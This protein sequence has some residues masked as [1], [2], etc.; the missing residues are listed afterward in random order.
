MGKYTIGPR[1]HD[2]GCD[3]AEN[4]FARIV[5]DGYQS[6]QLAIPK[7]IAGVNSYE[8]I[9]SEV[10][11][12]IREALDKYHL[13]VGVLGNYVE[14]AIDDEKERLKN[15]EIF[16]SQLA[17][18]K[19]LEA[20]CIGT[21]TTA[22]KLQPKGT[23]RERGLY[24]LCKSLE[25]ILPAAEN[26]GVNVAIEAVS[27]HSMNTP[28]ATKQVLDTMG[29]KFLKVIFDAGNLLTLPD[30]NN[31]RQLWERSAGLYGDR[32]VAIHY[33][34]Q[35]FHSNGESFPASQGE[36][37]ID[38]DCVFDVFKDLPQDITVLRE[39]ANPALASIDVAEL[40]RLINK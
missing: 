9:T 3:K 28:E 5:A 15:M 13:E 27:W 2:Y 18:A 33:K 6:M 26:L 17:T 10:I 7:A 11:R 24:L 21:E 32:I 16:K 23:T 37:V 25:Q 22:M 1:L 34:T 29:S 20:K 35:G 14:L 12:E 4:I 31:Q 19:A 36:N 30:V 8:Q 38:W 39:E 40:K